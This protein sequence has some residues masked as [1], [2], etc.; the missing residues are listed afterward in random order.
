MIPKFVSVSLLTLAAFCSST[1]GFAQQVRIPPTLHLDV[2]DM[3]QSEIAEAIDDHLQQMSDLWNG[4][5]ID[6][7]L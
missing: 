2:E 3:S 4:M 1:I 6:S 5:K 7:A